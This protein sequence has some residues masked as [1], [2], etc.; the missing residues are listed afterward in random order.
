MVRTNADEDRG[1]HPADTP[2]DARVESEHGTDVFR[3]LIDAVEPADGD[4]FASNDEENRERDTVVVEERNHELATLEN[5]RKVWERVKGTHVA[6]CGEAEEIVDNTDQQHKPLSVLGQETGFVAK[7]GDKGF[8]SGKRRVYSKGDKHNEEDERP[9]AAV[10]HGG[11][12]LWVDDKDER[13]IVFADDFVDRTV[14]EEGHVSEGREDDTARE[15]RGCAVDD[16]GG[17][18]IAGS[19][20][21]KHSEG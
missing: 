1:T 18:G 7:T 19:Q 14:R 13:C 15:K 2:V 4:H 16:G 20:I 12:G 17:H 10:V 21:L 8:D 6:D 5:N 9:E 3:E 11:E